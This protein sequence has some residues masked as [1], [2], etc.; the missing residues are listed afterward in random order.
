[1][2]N[3]K[4]VRRNIVIRKAAGSIIRYCL[5]LYLVENLMYYDIISGYERQI[6]V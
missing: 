3:G 1:M 4:S 6:G 5:F 2:I